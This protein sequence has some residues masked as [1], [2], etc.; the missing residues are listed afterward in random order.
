MMKML[1]LA[2]LSVYVS[3]VAVGANPAARNLR[4][5]A[6]AE[7]QSH[8]A[9]AA[10]GAWTKLG[11]AMESKWRPDKTDSKINIAMEARTRAMNVPHR[12]MP[13]VVMEAR[14]KNFKHS[15]KNR[16]NSKGKWQSMEAQGGIHNAPFN[17]AA[18]SAKKP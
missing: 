12:T 1:V 5:M 6:A 16:G 3:C 17:P 7:A 18:A 8:E 13:N 14:N 15:A 2:T 4:S 11:S 9:A 10:P